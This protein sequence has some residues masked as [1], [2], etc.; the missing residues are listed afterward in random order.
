MDKGAWWATVHGVTQ[1]PTQP[2][3]LSMHLSQSKSWNVALGCT[4][5]QGQLLIYNLCDSGQVT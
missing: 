2:K 5:F 3:S 1:S 4:Y